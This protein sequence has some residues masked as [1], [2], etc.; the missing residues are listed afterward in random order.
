MSHAHMHTHIHTH[1][2]MA[3]RLILPRR[4]INA[5][6][7]Q[8]QCNVFVYFS[9]ESLAPPEQPD[10]TPTPPPAPP[11][12]LQSPPLPPVLSF[13]N[14]S[15]GLSAF[16]KGLRWGNFFFPLSLLPP[17]PVC[18]GSQ[19]TSSNI[20]PTSWQSCTICTPC[21]GSCCHGYWQALENKMSIP[22]S[23]GSVTLHLSFTPPPHPISCFSSFSSSSFFIKKAKH[24]WSCCV[25]CMCPPPPSL[26]S[27]LM[28]M[29]LNNTR[30]TLVWSSSSSSSSCAQCS[31]LPGSFI[32]LLLKNLSEAASPAAAV[33]CEA[34]AC[35]S[36]AF[37]S[38]RGRGGW[39]SVIPSNP[40]EINYAIS[41][42]SLWFLSYRCMANTSK[43]VDDEFRNLQI[44]FF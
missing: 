23:W 35:S 12:P 7:T 27:H 37:T 26:H 8:C 44:G 13:H 31:F 5:V 3:T 43:G 19:C 22:D 20:V 32:H 1:K 11:P 40:R 42:Q 6:R 10:R 9:P 17:P 28:L 16:P 15:R 24:L 2:A 25:V 41:Q 29:G 36:H 34:G 30:Y 14:W 18:S 21:Q 38:R 39:V 4:Q 33:T